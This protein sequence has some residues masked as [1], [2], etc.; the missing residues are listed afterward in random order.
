MANPIKFRPHHL[1]CM[2]TYKGKGYTDAFTDNFD[3]LMERLNAQPTELE[4]CK[5]PDDICAPRLCDPTDTNCHCY[6][7]DLTET[8][9]KALA[10]IKK[11]DGLKDLDYAKMI[12]LTPD[13]IKE[14]RASYKTNA[15]RTACEGCEW[16]DLCSEI[17]KNN[18]EDTKL[19]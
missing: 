3:K 2:L 12:Y 4:I 10:D 17:A 19:K 11:I 13:L 14:L 15:I 8:D 1:L 18:F 5:G 9:E 6:N 16:V 7:D